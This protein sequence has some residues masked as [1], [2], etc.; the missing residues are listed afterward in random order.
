MIK[1][2][3]S[4]VIEAIQG[5]IAGEVPPTS[6]GGVSTDSRSVAPGELF[7]AVVG[8]RFDGHQF[9]AEALRRGAIGAVIDA[10][11]TSE[12]ARSL[13]APGQPASAGLLITV[14]DPVAALGK[15][16][17]YHRRQ[18]A[19]DVIA[20]VGSNGKTTTKAMI[21]HIL[22]GRM[23]GRCS[24]K[25]FNNQIGVPLTLLSAQSSDEYLV[26]EIGT[27]APGEISALAGIAQ[28]ELAVITCV[29]EEH[30]EGLGDIAGVA[31]E[32]CSILRTLR[33]GGFAA[34]NSDAPEIRE[35]LADSA[36]TIAT[37][38]RDAGADLR[39]THT[40]YES[41][42]LRFTLNNRFEYRLRVPGAH[43][44]VNAAGAITVARRLAFEHEEIAARLETFTPPPM[45]VEVLQ[46]GKVTVINDAYNANPRSALAAFD[47]LESQPCRGRRI[48]V[49]GEMLEL[50]RRSAGLHRQVADRLARGRVDHVFLVGAAGEL[51]YEALTEN[52]LFGPSVERCPDVM[53]CQAR[54]IADVRDGDVV[55]L[56]AS[57]AVELDRLVAPL[58]SAWEGPTA[59]P[60][61]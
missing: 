36:V 58:R 43:N 16:A 30:L 6:V 46:L 24:P 32:E 27:N 12:V 5:R 33:P 40:S 14:R 20:V 57:R 61:K 17:A 52:S 59:T 19:A 29:G 23:R 38:G 15:L 54:L 60:V 11:K 1:L 55:L 42:W 35:H 4:E 18:F 41:P 2:I 31:R 53:A 49:F 7:F 50:G 3:L 47:V 9:V 22:S 25:S 21:D 8:P 51:M 10:S 45:R 56:K 34:V 28:P 26:V 39:L 13:A 37:F 44:A 48:V